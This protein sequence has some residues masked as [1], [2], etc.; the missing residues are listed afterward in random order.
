MS[1]LKKRSTSINE[2]CR[3]K[4]DISRDE[5]ALCSYIHY[6]CADSRQRVPGWCCDEKE[7]IAAFVGVTRAGLYKMASRLI[8]AELIEAGGAIPFVWRVTPLWIDT[9]NECKLSLHGDVN[10]VDTMR[11]LSLHGDVNKVD[12]H[13]NVEYELEK[14]EREAER[15]ELTPYLDENFSLEAETFKKDLA[16]GGGVFIELRDGEAGATIYDQIQPTTE[17]PTH[18]INLGDRPRSETPVELETALR[19]F[20]REWPN[21][22]KYGILENGHGAKYDAPKRAEIVKDFCCWAIESGRGADTYRQLNARLQGWFRN[23]QHTTWKQKPQPA[24]PTV[25]A[26]PKN[27][28]Q[29]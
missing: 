20:Y 12:T 10:K 11:K 26:L 19:N 13:I 7:E 14:E 22:W 29:L 2:V 18:R 17:P 5:Y 23:E 4:L 6:R 1:D 3:R 16:P 15:E 25:S 28:L 24:Q 27:I 9:E 8:V 21:E